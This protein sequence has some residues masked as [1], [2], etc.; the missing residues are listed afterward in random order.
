MRLRPKPKNPL[1]AVAG[2][3]FGVYPIARTFSGDLLVIGLAEVVHGVNH[4]AGVFRV[5]AGV[6]AVAEIEDVAVARAVT[7]QYFGHLF[8]Y[9]PG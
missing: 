5:D 1:P 7:R 3:V 6:D 9:V 2:F 8:A 4:G